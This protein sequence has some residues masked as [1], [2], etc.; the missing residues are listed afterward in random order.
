[1]LFAAAGFG[2]YKST[3][4]APY[5]AAGNAHPLLGN[6]HL[7]IQAVAGIASATVVLGALALIPAVLAQA[8]RNPPVRRKIALAI[9]QLIVFASVTAVIIAVAHAEGPRHS[10]ALGYGAAVLW[11]I[12][13]LG[14]G[15][16]CV[17]ACRA[18]LFAVPVPAARL[19][20]ALACGT[21]VTL[22]MFAIT[23]ATALY[24]IG[25]NLDA[26]HLAGAP[27][28]PFQLLSTTG[29]LVVEL[30]VMIA[31][32]GLA[33]IATRRGWRAATGLDGARTR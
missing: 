29:S 14:C 17:L 2:F 30:I 19:R 32:S 21:A 18:A 25:L 9:L 6:A 28:G 15:V 12:A 1:V 16:S 33:A 11:G 13:G 5:P 20:A 27:N 24:A 8:R 4:D 23:G 26:A 3:E 7:A 31:A 22:A 10:S